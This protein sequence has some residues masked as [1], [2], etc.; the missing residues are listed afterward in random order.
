MGISSHP[1]RQKQQ[2]TVDNRLK[3]V[4]SVDNF[5]KSHFLKKKKQQKIVW[6]SE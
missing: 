3:P 4:F 5:Y 2:K 1:H 6:I